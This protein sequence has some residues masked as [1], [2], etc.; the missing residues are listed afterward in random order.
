M[1]S[2]RVKNRF[3]V[4]LHYTPTGP[5]ARVFY[6]VLRAGHVIAGTEHHIRREKYP[7]HEL[8]LCL[9]GIGH[10]SLRGRE[11]PVRAGELV[12]IDCSRPHEYR[13]D[14]RDPW[15][16]FWLRMEGPGL[17]RI[18]KMLSAGPMPV[19]VPLKPAAE[20]FRQ[21]FAAMVQS[22]PEALA[23]I[24]A[25]VA[26]LIALCFRGGSRNRTGGEPL[27]QNLPAI[28]RRPL[29]QMRTSFERPWRVAELAAMAGMSPSHFIRTFRAALGTSPIDWLRR[30]RIN[31]AK[32]R[33]VETDDSM[34]EIARQV[35]YSDQFFFSKD[36][37]Q[38]TS[39]TPTDY[40]KREKGLK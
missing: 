25:D 23:A 16:V 9:E 1:A 35:G 6:T 24:H 34:K 7:G 2:S 17:D 10:T 4:S 38:M 32:R 8:I 12:W 3:P 15:E 21:I 14:E 26:Q 18:C 22:S 36:F 19:S 20:C 11:V 27:P 28:L 40:R 29:E 13:A 37:K 39:L 31:Q 33:L 5:N 30:E